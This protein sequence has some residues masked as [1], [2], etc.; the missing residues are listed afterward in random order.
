VGNLECGIKNVVFRSPL[1]WVGIVLSEYGICRIV[2]PK[3]SKLSVQ[4]ELEREECLRGEGEKEKDISGVVKKAVTLLQQYFSGERVSFDL[5][6]DMRYYTT[7]QQAVW[8]ATAAIP[9]GETRSYSWVAKRIKNPKAVRAVGQ[10]LGANPVPLIIPC[11]R[12][13]SSAGTLGGFSGGIGM[14]EKLLDLEIKNK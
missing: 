7:F 2:L 14:K 6:L 12:V 9:Y 4:K 1:G 5:P 13:I 8:Q 10:A 11:H 3:K